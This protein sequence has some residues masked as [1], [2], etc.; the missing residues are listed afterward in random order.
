MG[1]I[2]YRASIWSVL[3]FAL[4]FT[5]L[6]LFSAFWQLFCTY[7]HI[8]LLNRTGIVTSYAAMPLSQAS[9]ILIVMIIGPLC[10]EILFRGLIFRRLD[11]L[12]TRYLSDKLPAAK[13]A[14]LGL[15]GAVGGSAALFAALHFDI[16]TFPVY[17]VIGVILALWVKYTRSL[18]PAW[19]LHIA[20]NGLF[21]LTLLVH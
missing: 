19:A 21:V 17:F 7:W 18:W 13:A 1:F 15:I 12:L 16:N 10:E 9:I 3:W 2:A 14:Q 20:F 11:E 4:S 8:G 5:H 6:V